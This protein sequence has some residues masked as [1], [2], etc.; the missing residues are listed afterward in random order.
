MKKYYIAATTIIISLIIICLAGF[1][2]V[3]FLASHGGVNALLGGI[4]TT[5]PAQIDSPRETLQIKADPTPQRTQLPL[6]TKTPQRQITYQEFLVTFKEKLDYYKN[7][8]LSSSTVITTEIEYRPDI[9]A[10]GYSV[11]G[12]EGIVL[13]GINDKDEI[14]SLAVLTK[15][16]GPLQ[17]VIISALQDTVGAYFG[18]PDYEVVENI[19]GY[20]NYTSYRF[21][22]G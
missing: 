17:A 14:G 5:R 19:E 8:L 7:S 4:E 3:S 11:N 16:D 2:V 15:N 21:N 1:F 10:V 18:P 13:C 9:D 22:L 6:P 20:E 12:N